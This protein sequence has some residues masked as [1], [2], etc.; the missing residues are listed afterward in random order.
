LKLLNV[1]DDVNVARSL[2]RMLSDHEVE[3]HTSVP[4]ALEMLQTGEAFD[5]I[6]CDMM[7]PEMT[8]PKFYERVLAL[9]PEL[10]ERVIFVTGGT[11]TKEATK[12][13]DSINSPVIIKPFGSEAIEAALRQVTHQRPNAAPTEV[14]TA[15]L[16]ARSPWRIA[17]ANRGR[18]IA[19]GKKGRDS[20]LLHS[21]ARANHASRS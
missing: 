7:M 20:R 4:A 11:F 16:T 15:S 6:L 17:G 14:G 21:Y 10:A 8:G 9:R 2:R 5:A 18:T 12:F 13:V 1:D 19:G 3:L